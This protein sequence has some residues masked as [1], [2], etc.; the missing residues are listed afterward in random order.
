MSACKNEEEVKLDNGEVVNERT[1]KSRHKE[2]V[3]GYEVEFEYLP[4]CS[5]SNEP[6]F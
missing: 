2:G 3:Q 4:D 6:G 1:Y 5:P